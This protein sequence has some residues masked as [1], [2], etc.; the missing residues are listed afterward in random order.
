MYL[1]TILIK[2]IKM[3]VTHLTIK[4]IKRSLRY[5]LFEKLIDVNRH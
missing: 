2:E 4:K 5:G 3:S 1:Y